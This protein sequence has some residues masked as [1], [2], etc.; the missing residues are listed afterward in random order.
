MYW[1]IV[2]PMKELQSF[3]SCHSVLLCWYTLLCILYTSEMFDLVENRQFLMLM[4]MVLQYL[5]CNIVSYN[6][7]SILYHAVLRWWSGL[8]VGRE[9]RYAVC[10]FW[11]KALHGSSRSAI[12]LPSVPQSHYLCLQVTGGE[13][14]PAGSGLLWWHWPIGYVSSGSFLF[15]WRS[16]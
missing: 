14:A 13:A 7:V 1:M 4:N 15:S 3:P 9:G 6:I 5:S 11:W 8:W 2:L 12:H 16:Q 10:P